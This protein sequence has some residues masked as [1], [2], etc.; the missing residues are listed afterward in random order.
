MMELPPVL[1]VQ[2]MT[3]HVSPTPSTR[4]PSVICNAGERWA[5]AATAR[6]TASAS[7]IVLLFIDVFIFFLFLRGRRPCLGT[8]SRLSESGLSY[9]MRPLVRGW[10]NVKPLL[11]IPE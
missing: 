4:G 3:A 10:E 6:P 2:A 1:V 9:G 11:S 7:S 8:A 5:E